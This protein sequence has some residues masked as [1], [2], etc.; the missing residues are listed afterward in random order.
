MIRVGLPKGRMLSDTRSLCRALGVDVMPGVLRYQARAGGAAVGIY[1]MKAP[2]IARMVKH[3]ELDLGLTG[4]EWLMEH[5]VPRRQWCL[6]MSAYTAS[7]CLLMQRGDPR[8]PGL[9]RSVV[10]PYPNLA[11]SLMADLVPGAR[12]V[13]VAGSSEGLVPDLGDACLDLVETG[14]T[15]A[16]NGLVVRRRFGVVTTHLARSEVSCAEQVGPVVEL[17]AG[18]RAVVS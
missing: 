14:S 3:G 17:L 10:T 1:L 2:D 6:E 16:V 5:D 13:A 7:V 15:A 18:A 11:R 4:D 9:V 12:I 8:E